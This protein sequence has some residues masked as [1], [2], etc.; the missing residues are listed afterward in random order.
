MEK[1]IVQYFEDKPRAGT[2]LIAKGFEREH[3][4]VTKL[5]DKYKEDFEEFGTLKVRKVITKGRPVSEMLLNEEQTLLLGSYMRNNKLVRKFKMRMVAEFSRMKNRIGE[6]EKHKSDPQYLQVRD[7]GKEV[8]FQA[9][10]TIKDFIEYAKKQGSQNSSRYY[11]NLT[12][13]LN[14]MLF[15]INGR[16][17]NLRE[18]MTIEQLMTVSSAEQI[19]KKGIIEGMSSGKFYKDI[20]QDV[21]KN[22][23]VFALLHGQSEVI[24]NLLGEK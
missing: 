7:A 24:T 19:I 13:M 22:V 6:L 10:D 21:K 20:Y 3:K 17:K 5:I 9:T 11:G 1:E 18:V 12:K 8:R 2:F 4:M 14:G 16:Y 15:I 23:A